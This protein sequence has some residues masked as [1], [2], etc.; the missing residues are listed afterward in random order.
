MRKYAYYTYVIGWMFLFGSVNG[1]AEEEVWMRHWFQGAQSLSDNNPSK[2]IEEYTKAIENLDIHAPRNYLNLYIARG[3]AYLEN[4]KYEDAIKD[5][6]V[7]INNRLASIEERSNALEGRAQAFFGAGKLQNF[8]A[9]TNELEKIDPSYAI[10][11]EESKNY[12]VFKMG[13]RLRSDPNIK[14]AFLKSLQSKHAID[15]EK[16]VIFT[17]TG[18]GLIRKSQSSD[19][20]KESIFTDL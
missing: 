17:P 11:Y 10:N 18:I 12:V 9:D 8:V 1:Y 14:K 5:F 13:N 4:S 2:A 7:V 6:N 3:T 20:P 19:A 15:S 16:D